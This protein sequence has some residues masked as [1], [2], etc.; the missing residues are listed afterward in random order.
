LIIVIIKEGNPYGGQEAAVR[1][2][3]GKWT[4]S[5]LGNEC[6]K[7]VLSLCLF[8]LHAQYIMQNAGLVDVFTKKECSAF[9]FIIIIH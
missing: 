4:G 5:K 2:R 3:H 8:N 7:A 1:N 6:V 9:I